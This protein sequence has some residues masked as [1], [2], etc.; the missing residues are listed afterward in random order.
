M[1]V[2]SLTYECGPCSDSLSKNGLLVLI[3]SKY[4]PMSTFMC[5]IMFFDV[6]LVDGPLNSF[7]LF[8]QILTASVQLDASGKI[9]G[10]TNGTEF[11]H[12]LVS[13]AEFCYNIWNLRFFE[14]LIPPF[15]VFKY[16]S[17]LSVI[18][19]QYIPAFYVLLVCVVFFNILPWAFQHCAHSQ[20]AI[21]QSIA[22]KIERMCIRLRY[23]WSVRNSV[24][25]SLT[26]FLVL[27]YARITL[28]TFILLTPTTLYGPGGQSS[29][30]QEQRVWYDGTMVYFGEDHFPYAVAALVALITFVLIPFLLLL[31][32]PLLPVLMARIGLQDNW[33]IRKMLIIPL[34]KLV[35]I[36]DVFQSCYKDEYRFFAGLL[37][38]Y[39]VAA[40]AIFAYTPTS[41]LNLIWFQ[42]FLLIIL[43]LHCTAQPYKKRWHN[44]IEGSIFTILAGINAV[45]F[46][47]LFQAQ[48]TETSTNVSFW[49][50]TVLLYCPLIYFMVYVI[51]KFTRWLHPRIVIIKDFLMRRFSSGSHSHQEIAGLLNN[52]DFPAR[53]EGHD[54]DNSSNSS[55]PEPSEDDE[56]QQQPD[57]V[58]ML[59]WL[60][61]NELSRYSP[62]G[63]SW[64]TQ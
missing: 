39:R 12:D 19:Q 7:I 48:T 30:Y 62:H 31:S 28:V 61:S 11:G 2:N 35:P 54:D 21:V 20:L 13:V 60:D 55:S 64:A 16:K 49:L 9:S 23:Q 24:I 18:V 4:L 6:S 51:F 58:E 50:Q 22:L 5:L 41:A 1:Y 43:L 8:S 15:C 26:T 47:R 36:F 33:I 38:I 53:M 52:Q 45:S 27:S 32:Y 34:N 3:V 40:L 42:G 63:R 57:D 56:Q 10:P 14:F 44:L 17:A 25:H 37:F 46:Y 29:F 59:N